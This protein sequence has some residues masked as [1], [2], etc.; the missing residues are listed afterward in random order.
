LPAFNALHIENPGK[1]GFIGAGFVIAASGWMTPREPRYG[2]WMLVGI[3]A[4]R[5]R[6]LFRVFEFL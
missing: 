4:I 3:G 5:D 6:N 1:R 2:R